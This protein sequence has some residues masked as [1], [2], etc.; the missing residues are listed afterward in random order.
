M[1]TVRHIR[2]QSRLATCAAPIILASLAPMVPAQTTHAAAVNRTI[3]LSPFYCIRWELLSLLGVREHALIPDFCYHCL[4]IFMF[5]DVNCSTGGPG[6]T[7]Y[8]CGVGYNNVPGYAD[9]ECAWGRCNHT[10]CCARTSVVHFFGPACILFSL[11]LL[12]CI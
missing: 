12:V 11:V 7:P 5:A 8:I 9:V 4:T 1:A 10:L 3:Q 6:Y 2:A